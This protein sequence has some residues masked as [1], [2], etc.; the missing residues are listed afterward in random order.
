MILLR[1]PKIDNESNN[2]TLHLPYIQELSLLED[3]LNSIWCIRCASHQDKGPTSH[4][5]LGE[6]ALLEDCLKSI[7]CIRCASHK[8][9][10][11][12]KYIKKK[13]A[14]TQC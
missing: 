2:P 9:Q 11:Q 6:I 4:H 5:L 12:L 8:M 13:K 3:C 7:W 1:Q 14:H 10:F